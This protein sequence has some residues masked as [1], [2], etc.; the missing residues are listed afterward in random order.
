MM[1]VCLVFL[2]GISLL[3]V[4]SA[5]VVPVDTTYDMTDS[6]VRSIIIMNFL[7]AIATVVVFRQSGAP[8]AWLFFGCLLASDFYYMVKA[9]YFRGKSY[10]LGKRTRTMSLLW[11]AWSS[12]FIVILAFA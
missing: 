2:L 1:V 12:T 3:A 4:P 6:R 10:R 11:A 8:A 7:E 9:A 5:F